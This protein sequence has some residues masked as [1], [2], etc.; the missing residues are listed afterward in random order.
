V[1]KKLCSFISAAQGPGHDYSKLADVEKNNSS[2]ATGKVE[3][4]PCIVHILYQKTSI[5]IDIDTFIMYQIVWA[6]SATGDGPL[7][8]QCKPTILASFDW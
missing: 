8:Q 3:K 7:C 2:G 4:P 6:V 1:I 5:N